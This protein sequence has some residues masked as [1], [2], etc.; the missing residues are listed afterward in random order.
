MVEGG[1]RVPRR[2]DGHDGKVE[3]IN[4][5]GGD[6]GGD[7]ILLPRLVGLGNQDSSCDESKRH[8]YKPKNLCW[9]C[10]EEKQ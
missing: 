2:T 10:L 9:L 7:W 3:V 4:G 5:M 1:V 8:N 6:R